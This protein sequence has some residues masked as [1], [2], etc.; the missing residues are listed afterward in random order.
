MGGTAIITIRR[1]W[2]LLVASILGGC[3]RQASVGVPPP[4]PAALGDDARATVE[5]FCGDCHRLP[6]AS[7]FPQ[8]RW[9][10]EVRQGYDFYRSSGRND[11][12]KP[13]ERDAIRYFQDE[14]PQSLTI[15]RARD[16]IDHPSPL[17][18]ERVDL[19]SAFTVTDPAIAGLHWR[20]EQG[21][22]LASDMRRGTIE[23]WTFSPGRESVDVVATLPHPCRIVPLERSATG[24]AYTVSDLGSFLPADH[25]NGAI[26]RLEE[27]AD[28]F[29]LNVLKDGLSRMVEAHPLDVVSA[30]GP[31]IVASEFGWRSTGS[32]RLIGTGSGGSTDRILDP[33]HGVVAAKVADMDGDGRQDIVAAFGQEHETVDVYWGR[34]EGG[35]FEHA[36]VHAF[37]DP[38]WGSSGCEL[39]DL[40]GDGRMDILHA[41]G[42]TLDSGLAKPYHGIRCLRNLGG[43]RFELREVGLMPG[44]CQA[45]AA[46]LDGDGDLDVVACSL[47]QGAALE[48]A[49]SFDGLSWF[50][51]M[52]GGVFLPHSIERDACEHACLALADVDADGRIDLVAG[53][54]RGDKRG[55]MIPSGVLYRNRR[56][57]LTVEATGQ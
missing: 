35:E 52:S 49:G 4:R 15:P 25:A 6:L 41:N 39:V 57:A 20:Q 14:A 54:W 21:D 3:S 30:G 38:S 40:D 16:R 55:L 11:L 46:D 48:E 2:L 42:D 23:R 1:A 19:P 22:L 36:E 26:W 27:S 31:L 43:R 7:S 53:V 24:R 44:V 13:I 8:D 32:L 47:H 28:G 18:F 29:A 12:P 56:P 34:A 33:R 10:A 37:P 9:P 45:S 17:V 5:R 50:E 51:Q